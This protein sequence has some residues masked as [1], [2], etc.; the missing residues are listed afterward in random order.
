DRKVVV[1]DMAIVTDKPGFVMPDDSSDPSKLPRSFSL[2]RMVLDAKTGQSVAC[3]PR[4][5]ADG[6]F[7]STSFDD[8]A[9]KDFAD[10]KGPTEGRP[11]FE[12]HKGLVL[13]FPFDSQK[14]TYQFRELHTR[15]A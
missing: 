3:K 12:G 10:D 6:E 14:K 13:K 15:D 9:E 5:R 2:E 11:A 4:K 8:E 7:V 1:Y